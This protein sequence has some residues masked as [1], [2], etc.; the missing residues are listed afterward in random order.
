MEGWI[1]GWILHGCSERERID[2]DLGL[3]L[4]M[5][6]PTPLSSICRARDRLSG[7]RAIVGL[8]SFGALSLFYE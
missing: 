7:L 3:M 4:T 2:L 1:D 6:I 5:M 8:V